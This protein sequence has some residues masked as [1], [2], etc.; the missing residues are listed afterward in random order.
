MAALAASNASVGFVGLGQMGERI[1]SRLL[2]HGPTL[3]VSSRDPARR[4]AFEA[5]GAKGARRPKELGRLVGDG[6]VFVMARD[7][8]SVASVLFGASGLA[9]G[10][11]PG[12]LVID[13]TT[14]RPEEA[15]ASAAR[16][17]ERG[18][19][20]LDA[21][22]GG[23][24]DA[25]SEGSLVFFVGGEASDLERA[26]PWFERLGRRVEHFGPVGMGSAVK[27]VNNLLTIGHVALLAE[28]LAFGEGMGLE[29][30]RLLE[31][32][33]TGGA[34]SV[35]LERKRAQLLERRYVPEFR[36][37][38][39]VKDLGLVEA[40]ARAAG[41]PVAM[42]R[43]ARRLARE[44]VAAGHGDEDFSVLFE[45]ALA[46]RQPVGPVAA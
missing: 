18:I 19:H 4:A 23:S 40:S 5:K 30:P 24:I 8:R 16:L 22:V 3:V 39:A 2:G 15:R 20:Y 46:R 35:M 44:G 29:R 7:G 28:A 14:I 25:A 1:A 36:L 27:L 13:L 11:A 6:L 17:A 38:L 33:A 32:L 37:A 21:P 12:A 42:T 9:A 45:A 31:V 43:E 10:L 34:R 41:V 26:R